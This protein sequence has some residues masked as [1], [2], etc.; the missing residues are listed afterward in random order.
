MKPNTI[1]SILMFTFEDSNTRYRFVELL[2][3]SFNLKDNNW[4]NES[5]YAL[6][7]S[8]NTKNEIRAIIY[9]MINDNYVFNSS[10]DFVDLYVSGAMCDYKD[11][12]KDKIIRINVPI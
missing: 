4:L 1:S 2:N 9:A 7:Y 8:L 12:N 10:K 3:A 5:T 6:P 11:T